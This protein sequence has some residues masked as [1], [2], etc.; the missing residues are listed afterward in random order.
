[1]ETLYPA[2]TIDVIEID[3]GVT[4][5]AFDHLGLPTE[6]NI[7][8]YNEDARQYL[9]RTPTA[10]YD[11]IFGDAFNDFSVPYHL[12]TREFNELVATWLAP[13]GIYV[14]NMIDGTSGAFLGAIVHTLQ[15]T[16]AYVYV[17]PNSE[18]WRTT[19]RTTYVVLASATPLDWDALEQISTPARTRQFIYF[20]LDDAALSA[21]LDEVNPILLTDRYAPVEQL[22]APVFRDETPAR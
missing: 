8:T 9:L 2:A 17:A 12:T 4:Q 3:P 19:P 10:G 6:T 20:V 15:Q 11:L 14:L 16:F 13:G 22:L 7:T 21:F 1:M 5:V 18:S